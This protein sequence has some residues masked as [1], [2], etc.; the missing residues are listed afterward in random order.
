MSEVR[1]VSKGTA[2]DTAVYVNGK[3][4]DSAIEATWSC[5]VD[6]MATATVTFEGVEVDIQGEEDRTLALASRLESVERDL[7]DMGLTETADKAGAARDSVVRYT[8]TMYGGSA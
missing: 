2:F 6:E 3:L 4:V 8:H 1:I 5:K 7:R